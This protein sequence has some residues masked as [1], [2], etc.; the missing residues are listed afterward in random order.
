MFYTSLFVKGIASGFE[1]LTVHNFIK[2]VCRCQVLMGSLYQIQIFIQPNLLNTLIFF[3][4]STI[5]SP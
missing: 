1:N 4:R 5:P 2:F 3:S